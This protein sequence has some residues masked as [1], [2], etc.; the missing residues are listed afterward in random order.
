MGD[1]KAEVRIVEE[2]V[3]ANPVGVRLFIEPRQVSTVQFSSNYKDSRLIKSTALERAKA[4][5]SPVGRWF[6]KT[7]R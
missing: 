6:R 3:E 7:D 5:N 1:V 2:L 4:L